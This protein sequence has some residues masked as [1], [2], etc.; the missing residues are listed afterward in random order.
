MICSVGW[1]PV[2]NLDQ[3]FDTGI[4]PESS[5]FPV[6]FKNLAKI[7]ICSV[8]SIENLLESI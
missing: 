8:G 2:S 3:K 5:E 1:M 4:I 7:E 6:L